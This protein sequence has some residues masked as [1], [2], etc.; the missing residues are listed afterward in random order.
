MIRVSC[1][2]YQSAHANVLVSG[3]AFIFRVRMRGVYDV[4][5]RNVLLLIHCVD[6]FHMSTLTYFSHISPSLG[7]CPES[8]YY[9]NNVL[10]WTAVVLFGKITRWPVVNAA[11]LP[12]ALVQVNSAFYKVPY[13][14]DELIGDLQ[15]SNKLQNRQS[16]SCSYRN[17][18]AQRTWLVTWYLFSG[19]SGSH[20]VSEMELKCWSRWK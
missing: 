19:V 16:A 10:A 17:V 13:T 2:L 12:S 11:H 8:V 4:T 7:S 14:A 20:F 1:L 3:F 18:N 15:L 5:N 9:S 6:S